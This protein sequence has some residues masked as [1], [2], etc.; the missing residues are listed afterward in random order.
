MLPITLDLSRIRVILIGEGGAARRRLA[1]LDEAGAGELEVYAPRPDPDLAEK[2]GARL[3]RRLPTAVEIA[4]AQLV[5]LA[6][7]LEPAAASIRR[8]AAAAGVLVNVEDDRIR[9]DFH[10]AAV[11]RRGDLVVAVS[12]EGRSPGLAALVRR[13]LERHF[14]PEWAA[15]LD[16]ISG[17][18][19]LWRSAGADP[20]TVQRRIAEWATARGWIAP[21][22]GTAA[23]QP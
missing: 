21:P 11:L 10:S 15:R 3:R 16:E 2:A 7:L 14:G 18:R 6:R 4:R 17:R 20:A 19:A 13:D 23:R 8:I 5:F 1:R 9:S 22:P 12:T